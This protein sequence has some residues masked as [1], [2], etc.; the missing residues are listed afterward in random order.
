MDKDL[1]E[2]NRVDTLQQL[3]INLQYLTEVDIKSTSKRLLKQKLKTYYVKLWKNK[4]MLST[5][6]KYFKSFKQNILF[7]KYLA[8]LPQRNLRLSLTK[9]RL[10][11]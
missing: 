2:K 5:R 4:L 11:D 9:L 8:L 3:I 10:S 7:K 1:Q 6:G